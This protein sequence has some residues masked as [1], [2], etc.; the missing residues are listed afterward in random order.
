MWIFLKQFNGSKKDKRIWLGIMLACLLSVLIIS[1]L[2]LAFFYHEHKQHQQQQL[3]QLSQQLAK[4]LSQSNQLQTSAQI[5]HTLAII[6]AM[7]QVGAASI[8]LGEHDYQAG[9]INARLFQVNQAINAGKAEL[10]LQSSSHVNQQPFIHLALSTLILSSLQTLLVGMMALFLLW[11]FVSRHLRQLSQYCDQL[12][13]DDKVPA[14]VFADVSR[15][16]DFNKVA[17]AINKIQQYLRHS[18]GQLLQSKQTLE[19]VF[20]ERNQLLQNELAYKEEL[21]KQIKEQTKEVEQSLLLLSHTQRIMV[22]QEKMAALSGLVTGVAHEINTPIGVCLTAAS[23]Q[24]ESLQ[25]IETLLPLPSTSM[26]DITDR[27]Q[28]CDLA[29]RLIINNVTKAGE[30]IQRFKTVAAQ[31]CIESRYSK[32]LW[33]VVEEIE[34]A[35]NSKFADFDVKVTLRIDASLHVTT[36][37]NLLSQIISNLMTNSYCHAFSAGRDNQLIVSAQTE[38]SQ[39]IVTV[40]DN[41]AGVSAIEQSKIFEP[42][43]TTRR[44]AGNTGLGLSA[45]F[46]AAT[47]LQGQLSYSAGSIGACFI[48]NIPAEYYYSGDIEFFD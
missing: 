12:M 23:S 40:E 16:S 17:A 30:L 39:V 24:Q 27:L 20:N 3:T 19:E 41:G 15:H 36:D 38:A 34:Q 47:Q 32:N 11:H 2:Q 33:Q 46:N 37:Q 43:Y 45:A 28:E 13:N 48:L 8:K 26:D 22:E 21:R 44:S 18:Y 7:P 35:V 4:Q 6:T 31:Q 5:E 29:S 9:A 10:M 1:G 14:L 42:F 25:Q